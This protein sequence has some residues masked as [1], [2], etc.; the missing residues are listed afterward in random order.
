V[1]PIVLVA[2]LLIPLPY[3]LPLELVRALFTHLSPIEV[4][5]FLLL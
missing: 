5:H 2:R 3:L 4:V 1:T